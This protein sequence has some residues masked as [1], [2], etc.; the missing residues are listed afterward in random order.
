MLPIPKDD[1]FEIK[2]KATWEEDQPNADYDE[3][4]S[5][6][7]IVESNPAAFDYSEFDEPEDTA[8]DSAPKRR[9]TGTVTP[10]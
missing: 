10:I 2:G 5:D 4:D 9:I 8:T 6:A 3:A 7:E 1:T